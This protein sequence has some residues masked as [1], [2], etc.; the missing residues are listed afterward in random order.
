[1]DETFETVETIETVEIVETLETA[2][3]TERLKRL[4]DQDG[5]LTVWFNHGFCG[6]MGF[7]VEPW[8]YYPRVGGF[9]T[10]D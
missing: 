10:P 6:L 2:E 5:F 4:R 3:T 9:S 8:F 7:L 1:M